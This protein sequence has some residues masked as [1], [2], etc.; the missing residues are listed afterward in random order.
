MCLAC[1][2]TQRMDAV[3]GRRSP[4]QTEWFWAELE[5]TRLRADLAEHPYLVAWRRGGLTRADL[6]A[7]ATEHEHVVAATAAA[8]HRVAERSEGLLG[9]RLAVAKCEAEADVVHWRAFATAVCGVT[10]EHVEPAVET[11]R[12][13][14][15]LTAAPA[16]SVSTAL[17]ALW[18]VA[19][20]GA[21]LVVS[22]MASL[23]KHYG[24]DAAGAVW[25]DRRLA[26]TDHLAFLEAAVEGAL[27]GEDALAVLAAARTTFAALRAVYDGLDRRRASPLPTSVLN[28]HTKE[29]AT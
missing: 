12:C 3:E 26:A 21:E 5:L 13:A 4:A 29:P 16:C 18:A 19:S 8:T 1:R 11:V 25:F 10:P 9:D 6:M 24:I 27:A 28:S 15:A 2:V 14:R 23:F 17:V 20:A 22:P 7:F